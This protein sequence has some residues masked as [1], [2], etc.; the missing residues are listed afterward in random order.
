MFSILIYSGVRIGGLVKLNEKNIDYEKGLF[1]AQEKKTKNSSGF[2]TSFLPRKF[3]PELTSFIKMKDRYEERVIQISTKQV[4]KRLKKYREKWY[5]HL[6]RH[7]IRYL[8][9][10]KGMP[11]P[12][13]TAL[14]NHMPKDVDE[15]YLRMLRNRKYLRKQ[16]DKYFPY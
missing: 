15:V 9:H 10:K 8:W 16:Y 6:F 2:N 3:M 7:T 12:E 11:K 14:L 4:R 5:P 1:V 13:G